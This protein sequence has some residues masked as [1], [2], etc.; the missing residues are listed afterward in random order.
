MLAH[1]FVFPQMTGV[2]T[3]Q[4]ASQLATT[5]EDKKRLPCVNI[6]DTVGGHVGVA[7]NLEQNRQ[8]EKD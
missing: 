4:V 2:F 1:S 5:E 3:T 6:V 8:S 7:V